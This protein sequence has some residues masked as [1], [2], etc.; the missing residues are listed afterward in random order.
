VISTQSNVFAAQPKAFAGAA[1]GVITGLGVEGYFAAVRY[2]LR[3]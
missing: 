1:V 2:L 3:A